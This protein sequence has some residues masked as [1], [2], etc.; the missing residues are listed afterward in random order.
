MPE[1]E[2]FLQGCPDAATDIVVVQNWYKYWKSAGLMKVYSAVFKNIVA[3]LDTVEAVADNISTSYS[4]GDYYGTA[5][6]A[7]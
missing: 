7:S 6:Y 5:D 2:G 3:N 1:F 4:N